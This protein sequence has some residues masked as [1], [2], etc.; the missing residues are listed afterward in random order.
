[1]K[2]C[3]CVQGCSGALCGFLHTWQWNCL[4]VTT[5]ARRISYL[6]VPSWSPVNLVLQ[7]FVAR[8]NVILYMSYLL[9]WLLLATFG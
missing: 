4:A 5:H 1:M 8:Q 6:D 3:Y 9:V 7:D 2:H